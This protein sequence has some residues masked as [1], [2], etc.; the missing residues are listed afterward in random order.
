[1]KK[2]ILTILGAAF[3]TAGVLSSTVADPTLDQAKE[4]RKCLARL[5]KCF[6]PSDLEALLLNPP[7]TQGPVGD[8]TCAARCASTDNPSD[9]ACGMTECIV[10]CEVAFDLVRGFCLNPP[11]IPP[12]LC[13]D[14]SFPPC[15]L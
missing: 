9:Q 1:M 12:F 8:N 6:V 2:V 14:G 5:H 7:D 4:S 13:D 15:P 10:L 3:L 11:S